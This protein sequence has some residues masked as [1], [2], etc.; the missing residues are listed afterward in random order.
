MPEDREQPGSPVT[1]RTLA[2]KA[3][4]SVMAVSLALRRQP[5]VSKATSA[6][7]HRIAEELGYVP[8]PLVASLMRCRGAKRSPDTGHVIGWYGAASSL[9]RR[10]R[11][12]GAFDRFAAHV[13]GARKACQSR[14]MKL[15]VF[16]EAVNE[17]PLQRML[18]HRGIRGLLLGPKGSINLASPLALP[19][20]VHVVQIGRSRHDP[21]HDRITTDFFSAACLCIRALRSSGCQR[22]GFIDKA[23]H[24]A[25]HERLT[26]AA[27]LLERGERDCPAEI[28]ID[29]EN[30]KRMSTKQ[31]HAVHLEAVTRYINKYRPEGVVV[32]SP[33]LIE[34]VQ[35]SGR[36]V[37]ITCL[38]RE[39]LPKS[40]SGTESKSYLIGFEAARL[41]IEKI[42]G[43]Q[44]TGIPSRTIVLEPH[45]H[46]GT[47]HLVSRDQSGQATLSS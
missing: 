26:M 30:A 8:N 16:D 38:I 32:G 39:G 33:Y 19:N 14:G 6:K 42:L 1:Q 47:S 22:I 10:M 36:P 5:G 12:S 4:V 7:I 11:E 28:I 3:G 15:E 27:Y 29:P 35:N 37:A 2:E 25:R 13:A 46:E 18:T 24:L 40:L 9:P 43:P 17:L 20:S 31:A 41:L 34:A 44:D 21:S 45:W 23:N